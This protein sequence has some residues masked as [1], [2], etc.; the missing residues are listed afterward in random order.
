VLVPSTPP[1]V[2]PRLLSE[3]GGVAMGE[4]GKKV[5]RIVICVMIALTIYLM[6]APKAM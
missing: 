4:R 1:F 2:L 3:E 6:N 5:L